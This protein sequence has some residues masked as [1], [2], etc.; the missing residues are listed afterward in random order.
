M[1]NMTNTFNYSDRVINNTKHG[2]EVEI[3]F[4][5][6]IIVVIHIVWLFPSYTIMLFCSVNRR[7][8]L[9]GDFLS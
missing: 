5:E 6:N 4:G 3:S 7:E 1:N 8:Y 2:P 9:S